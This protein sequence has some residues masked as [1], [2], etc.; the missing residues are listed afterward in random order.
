MST[1][2][3]LVDGIV[4][5]EGRDGTNE[6]LVTLGSLGSEDRKGVRMDGLD[7]FRDLVVQGGL[8]AYPER[9]LIV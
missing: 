5:L 1:Y 4:L 9:I 6:L 3:C 8:N 7:W 2:S